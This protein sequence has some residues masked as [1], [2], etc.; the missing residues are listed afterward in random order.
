ML[1][2]N[3][4]SRITSFNKFKDVCLTLCSICEYIFNIPNV[5]AYVCS[6]KFRCTHERVKAGEFVSE[7]VCMCGTGTFR[8]QT[9]VREEDILYV[10]YE[11]KVRQMTANRA[12][13]VDSSMHPTMVGSVWS[14]GQL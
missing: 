3:S 4:L 5:C 7:N 8:L 1:S 14:T 13:L 9:G 10:N 6:C 12:H 2:Y 11:N